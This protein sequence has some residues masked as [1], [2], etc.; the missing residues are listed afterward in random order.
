MAKAKKSAGKVNWFDKFK[1]DKKDDK[2][3]KKGPALKF[4]SPEWKAKY[5]KKKKK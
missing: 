5:G 1:K 2:G 3:E 4:G